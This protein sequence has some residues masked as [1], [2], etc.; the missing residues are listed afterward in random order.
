MAEPKIARRR[1]CEYSHEG[2]EFRPRPIKGGE[3]MGL[4]LPGCQRTSDA[5]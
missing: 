4:Y 5:P 2:T 1:I 3:A